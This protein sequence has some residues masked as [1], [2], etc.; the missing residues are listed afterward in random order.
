MGI[1]LP[2]LLAY[3]VRNNIKIVKRN[4]M[5]ACSTHW[6]SKSLYAVKHGKYVVAVEHVLE[7]FIS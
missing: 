1:K 7:I 5:R 2:Q 3:P 4:G 6:T